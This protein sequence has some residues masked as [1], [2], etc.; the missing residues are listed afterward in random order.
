MHILENLEPKSVFNFF[1][2]ISQ[3]PRGSGNEKGIS[4]YIV[5]FAKQRNLKYIQDKSLNVIIYKDATPGREADGGLIFQSHMDM[6]CEQNSGT[7]HDFEKEPLKLRIDGDYIKATN[8]TLGADDGYGVAYQLALLDGNYNHPRLA[9]IFTVEEETTMKGAYEID[10]NL[11]SGYKYFFSLDSGGESFTTGCSS[12]LCQKIKIPINYLMTPLSFSSFII[13]V[14]GLKGGHSGGDI[15]KGLANANRLLGRILYNLFEKDILYLSEISGG[16]EDNAIPREAFATI[17]IPNE[18]I[19]QAQKLVET[20]L[21]TFE[22]EYSNT[23]RGI[24]INL[25]KTEFLEKYIT[26]EDTRKILTSILLIPNGVIE[27]SHNFDGIVESSN[28][29][30]VITTENQV[31]SLMNLTRSLALSRQDFIQKQIMEICRMVGG[32]YEMCNYSPAWE[33][34]PNSPFRDLCLKIYQ[35][36]WGKKGEVHITQGCTECG[37]FFEK[38]PNVDII[39]FGPIKHGIHSPEEMISI[40]STKKVWEFIIKVLEEVR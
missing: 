37:I 21:K 14:T 5:N 24:K 32:T 16:K 3:I 17:S 22:K 23:E 28:N 1:Y 36:M 30:G 11:L 7:N 13:S 38:L 34:N 4:D 19:D 33:F 12:C 18:K 29:L 10:G 6:V 40:S 25:D 8:T 35:Q 39:G 27:M 15:N 26:K 31:V 9:T 2:E 20:C